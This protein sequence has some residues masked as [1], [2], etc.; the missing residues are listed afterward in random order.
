MLALFF[1][2]SW[3][4]CQLSQFHLYRAVDLSVLQLSLMASHTI[5][6]LTAC[7]GVKSVVTDLISI[8]V[9]QSGMSVHDSMAFMIMFITSISS[10]SVLWLR[11]YSQSARNNY[12]LGL[13][14]ILM[15]HSWMHSNILCS[16]CDKLTS[17][18]LNI[19]TSGLFSVITLTSWAKQ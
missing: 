19:A 11:L 3:Q 5:H 1:Y 7:W 6:I 8:A 15:L 4:Y 17:S 10:I 2:H 12:D 13:Y 9:M 18:F 16:L 14:S